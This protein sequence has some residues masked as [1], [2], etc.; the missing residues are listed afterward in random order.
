MRKIA[1]KQLRS[2]SFARIARCYFNYFIFL[3]RRL[4][5]QL[6]YSQKTAEKYQSKGLKCLIP[7]IE[8]SHYQHFQLLAI[9]KALQLRGVEVKVLICDQYLD[10]CEI[11]SINNEQTDACTDCR[12]NQK[13]ILKYFDLSVVKLSEVMRDELLHD[14]DNIVD[15]INSSYELSEITLHGVSLKTCIDD[16]VI[17]YYFGEVPEESN[18]LAKVRKRHIKTA[19]RCLEAAVRFDKDWSPDLVLTNMTCYSAWEPFYRYYSQRNILHQLSLS[20][21][22]FNCLVY[23]SFQL[24]PAKDRYTRYKEFR[25]CSNLS[26]VE[27]TELNLF[28][29]NR[30]SGH[31]QIFK[32]DGY[33][34]Y[35]S[36]Q[37]SAIQ[38]LNISKQKR[39]LFLFSNLYWDVGLSDRGS[40][41]TTIAQ[42]TLRTIEILKSRE[43]I[44]LYIKPHPAEEFGTPSRKGIQQIIADHYPDGLKNMTIIPPS[45]K[46]NTYQLFPYIDLGVIF[47]GTLGL[48]MMLNHIPVVSTGM[49]SHYGLGFS[50][51]P[52]TEKEYS[53]FLLGELDIPSPNESD[54]NLFAYFYFIR[55]LMP[56][57]L[58]ERAYGDNFKGFTFNSL[59]DLTPGINASL[60]HLCDC[61]IKSSDMIPEAW[62]NP[63]FKR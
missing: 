2:N 17:R 61:L 54:L 28:L 51:E 41:Y 4:K 55:T 19:I 26:I 48:E 57:T 62:P 13:Y 46:I 32:R 44:H 56:W 12:F 5:R 8:T 60:D 63:I 47:N 50:A 10:G 1:L 53:K 11:K 35:P 7:L 6:R 21:Y 27:S 29:E 37:H 33:F 38:V 39:N 16:S 9:A 34:S 15:G 18:S 23:N 3:R 20:Q 45:M 22:N 42:W 43:D 59:D 31:S 36:C 52:A 14:L 49:T 40:L 58:T 24:F 25:K 30:F